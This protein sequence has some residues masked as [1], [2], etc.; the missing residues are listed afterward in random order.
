MP[1]F[2]AI[3]IHTVAALIYLGV[4]FRFQEGRNSRVYVVWYI[5]AACEALLQLGIA[6]YYDVLTLTGTHITERMMVLTVI[7][8]GTGVSNNAKNV[9]LIVSND[10]GESGDGWSKSLLTHE[11]RRHFHTNWRS[12]CNY[13]YPGS[14]HC[15]DLFLLPDI[16]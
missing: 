8:L 12:L 5:V 16:L 7:V 13:W 6:K 9:V 14:H 1:I 11:R 15:V 2:L 10:S 3:A 4:S